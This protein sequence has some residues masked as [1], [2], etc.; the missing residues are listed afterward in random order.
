MLLMEFFLDGDYIRFS[1]AATMPF[2][3]CVSL[4]SSTSTNVR[5]ITY[6]C[7]V[8]L[9]VD[10]YKPVHGRRSGRPIP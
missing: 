8:F 7:S 6:I 1:L 10:H 5:Y 4:V 2:L 3:F 9:D